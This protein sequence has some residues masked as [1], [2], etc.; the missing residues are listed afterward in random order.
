MAE[1]LAARWRTAD[2]PT[3]STPQAPIPPTNAVIF[4]LFTIESYFKFSNFVIDG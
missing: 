1:R 2:A 3:P 4:V